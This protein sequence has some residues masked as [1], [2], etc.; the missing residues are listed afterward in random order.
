MKITPVVSI[1]SLSIVDKDEF[2][3]H[4]K[5]QIPNVT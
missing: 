4:I 5:F 1:E 2:A 3:A